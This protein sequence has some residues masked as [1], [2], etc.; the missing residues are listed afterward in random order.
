[1]TPPRSSTGLAILGKPVS[2]ARLADLYGG[3]MITDDRLEHICTD[4]RVTRCLTPADEGAVA[5]FH[6]TM[7]EYILANTPPQT[8]QRLH[9]R[10]ADLYAADLKANDGD[11]DALDRLPVH[12]WEAGD[13]EA[14]V[15]AVAHLDSLRRRTRLYRSQLRDLGRLATVWRGQVRHRDR[16]PRRAPPRRRPQ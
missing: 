2:Y 5:I 11:L 3:G 7:T 8:K 16:G 9:H 13:V 10:A 4:S 12:L 15:G 6:A 14:F 1:M